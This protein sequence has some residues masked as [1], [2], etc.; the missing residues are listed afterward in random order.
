VARPATLA[1]WLSI[2]GTVIASPAMHAR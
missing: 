2:P 1:A